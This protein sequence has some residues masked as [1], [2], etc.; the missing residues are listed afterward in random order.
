MT[1]QSKS[2]QKQTKAKH[3][4]CCLRARLHDL[5]WMWGWTSGDV[6]LRCRIE[7]TRRF[8]T[9]SCRAAQLLPGVA[10]SAST[11]GLLL[12]LLLLCTMAMSLQYAYDPDARCA[13][14]TTSSDMRDIIA[15]RS[16]CPA[17]SK[18]FARTWGVAKMA[19]ECSQA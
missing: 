5:W 16:S 6:S 8:D 9:V 7:D 19:R 11:R 10:V 14:S 4:K 3:S 12:L 13:S 17:F 2:L 1:R 18:S 15:D